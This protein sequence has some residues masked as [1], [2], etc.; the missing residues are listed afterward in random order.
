L[1]Y[2]KQQTGMDDSNSAGF[3]QLGPFID[4]VNISEP[5]GQLPRLRIKKINSR[6]PIEASAPLSAYS[7]GEYV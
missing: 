2:T 5:K 6:G 4:I 1:K 7:S 3:G